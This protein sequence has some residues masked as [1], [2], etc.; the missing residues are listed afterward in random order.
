M[1]DVESIVQRQ[2]DAYNARDIDAFM[3]HWADDAQIFAFPSTILADGAAEI[4]A[5]HVARFEEPDL[6]ATLVSRM[7][8]GNAVVDREIVTRNFP[9]GQGRVN[10]IAI[11]HVEDGRIAKAWFQMGDPVLEAS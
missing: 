7:S 3:A 9:D 6:Y 10:V 5:R 11:Y 8:L 1:T 4:R 2:L